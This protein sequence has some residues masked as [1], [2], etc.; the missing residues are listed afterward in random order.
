[1]KL[2]H[3]KKKQAGIA[4]MELM[5][6]L[7]ILGMIAAGIAMIKPALAFQATKKQVSD[8]VDLI[9]SQ[10]QAYIGNGNY[11]QLGDDGIQ[12]LCAAGDL[13][14]TMCGTDN[15]ATGTN[16]FGGDWQV[17]ASD[18]FGAGHILIT[19]TDIP[20]GRFAEL[21]DTLAARSYK[22]CQHSE[23]CGSIVATAPT[24]GHGGQIALDI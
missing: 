4:L 6:A 10:A 9:A 8:G 7:A 22:G 12:T 2:Q 20:D 13:N 1:M 14:E 5:I 19:V 11:N 21:A 17:T 18:N 24:S 15:K 3:K 16:P 23:P